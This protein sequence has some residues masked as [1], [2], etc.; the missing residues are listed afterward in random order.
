MHKERVIFYSVIAAIIS[1]AISMAVTFGLSWS[2]TS[3][4]ET[5]QL[6]S[7]GES[8][9]KRANRAFKNSFELLKAFNEMRVDNCSQKHIDIMRGAIIEHPEIE[10]IGFIQDKR[11][12]CSSWGIVT[13]NIP[14]EP[15]KFVT[16]DNMQLTPGIKSQLS[17]SNTRIALQYGVYNVLINPKLFFDPIADDDTQLAVMTKNG[18][19]LIAVNGPDLALMQS[20]VAD[21]SDNLQEGRL[22]SVVRSGDLV[23]I[24]SESQA[25]LMQKIRDQNPK[26]L[27]F[28]GLLA[29]ILIAAIVWYTRKKLSPLSMLKRAIDNKEFIV[30]YQPII[31]LATGK[32]VGAEALVRW[33]KP[34]GS[35]VRPDLF[36]PLAE[37]SGLILPLTDQIIDNVVREMAGFL[38]TNPQ[39]HIAVN[40]SAQDMKTGRILG[41]MNKALLRTGIKQTQIWLEATEQ[42]LMDIKSA[43]IVIE[44]ARSSGY[45]VAIDDFGTGYSSL[46]HL[47]GLPLDTLKVDKSFVDTIDATSE[48]ESGSITNHI[49]AMA[50]TLKMTI[51]AEG[52]ENSDQASYLGALN[53]EYGQGWLYS[54]ALPAD[55]FLAY[56]AQK[57]AGTETEKTH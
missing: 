44:N 17:H 53:V 55:E 56:C 50:R 13:T 8:T 47:Q 21:S 45:R 3:S 14:E 27:L 25:T 48:Q 5:T 30:H 49:I 33:K 35:M 34:D 40:I 12:A 7:L 1:I 38:A 32:C 6:Q 16:K 46:S 36:I 9:L 20:L 24:T 43:K 18:D 54:K 19:N 23:A 4:S 11:L 42:G 51:V 39:M 31:N 41:V 29:A 22:F 37:R 2:L 52:I 57:E 15:G 26:T 10:E 28:G